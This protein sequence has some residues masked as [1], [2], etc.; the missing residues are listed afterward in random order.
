MIYR[1][2]F[3]HLYLMER[4]RIPATPPGDLRLHRLERPDSWE[5][6]LWEKMWVHQALSAA[7]LY[8]DYAPF[9]AR[10]AKHAGVSPEMLVMGAGIEDFI[11]TLAFLCCDPGDGMAYTWPTCAM[12]DIYAQ[13]VGAVPQHFVTY[14]DRDLSALD[15]AERLDLSTKLLI[16]PS[17]G[18]PID[19]VY[20]LDELLFLAARC[21]E[22]D[23]VLAIDEAYYG[24]GAATALPL[25]TQHGFENVL[26]LRTFSKAFGGAA[27]RVGYAIGSHLA[28][29]PLAAAR[30]S[31][32][33]SGPSMH[34]ANVLLDHWD[35]H[36]RP[37]IAAVVAGREWLREELYHAGFKARGM[38]ANHVL[39]DMKTPERAKA[40]HDA[41]LAK[42]ARVRLNASPLDRLL[43][44]TCGKRARMEKF[45]A[46]FKECVPHALA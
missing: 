26:I 31:G 40:T 4:R 15:I 3:Q 6:D 27:L 9:H 39:V 25:V 8:P 11:R 45:F 13:L 24:F 34:A 35:S 46:L 33:I 18:Q 41:L 5:V 28:I 10:L 19:A 37:G 30:S 21:R 22:L 17:P 42:G 2:C 44:V 23:A 38:W 20:T 36:V 16:L 14:P 43:M 12:F 7:N 1:R 32:E 29:A